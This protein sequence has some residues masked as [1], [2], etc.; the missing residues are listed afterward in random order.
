ML[1]GYNNKKV[2]AFYKSLRIK[3]IKNEKKI[4]MLSD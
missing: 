4:S 1:I 2:M 3:I